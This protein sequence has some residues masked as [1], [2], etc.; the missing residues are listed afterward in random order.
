MRNLKR[1][2]KRKPWCKR[3]CS[4]L[5]F[6]AELLRVVS[7]MDV[8]ALKMYCKSHSKQGEPLRT[9]QNWDDL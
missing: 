4:V 1:N 6:D 5:N 8:Y 9:G 7:K 2:W 3:C